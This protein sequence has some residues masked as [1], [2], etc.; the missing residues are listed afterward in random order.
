[1]FDFANIIRPYWP[2][3]VNTGHK[4]DNYARAA[5][6]ELRRIRNAVED[7]GQSPRDYVNR[8][9]G[10]QA[11]GAVS[12]GKVPTNQA[13]EVDYVAASG[14]W[15]LTLGGALLLGSTNG[16]TAGSGPILLPGEEVS[17]NFTAPTDYMV[18]VRRIFLDDRPSKARSGSGDENWYETGSQRPAAHENERDMLQVNRPVRIPPV[19][20]EN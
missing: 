8:I 13:W 5:L 4:C 11:N 20:A 18:Q 12:L 2:H 16:Y 3:I 14:A 10:L 15:T 9:S 17:I 7:A 19:V 6:G 1:M